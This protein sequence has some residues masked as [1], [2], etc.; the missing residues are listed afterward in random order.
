MGIIS[1]FYI[2]DSLVQAFAFALLT[3]CLVFSV[4]LQCFITDCGNLL[5]G[6]RKSLD[7]E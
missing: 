2:S 3:V 6:H 5:T 7:V 1:L 4:I